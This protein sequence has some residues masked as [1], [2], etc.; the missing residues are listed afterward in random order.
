MIHYLVVRLVNESPVIQHKF[1]QYS[2]HTFIGLRLHLSFIL[3][4]DVVQIFLWDLFSMPDKVEQVGKSVR[5][6]PLQYLS[7]EVLLCCS[8]M[9][10]IYKI[11]I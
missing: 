2:N 6:L 4:P 8:E 1:K 11:Y 9:L 7:I 10:N 5:V 3:K